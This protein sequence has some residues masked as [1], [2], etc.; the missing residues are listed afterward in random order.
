MSSS[1]G[2]RK[3]VREEGRKE[4]SKDK[5]MGRKDGREE[6]E[7]KEGREEG[8]EGPELPVFDQHFLSLTRLKSESHFL[9]LNRD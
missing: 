3:E 2:G 9:F 6:E 5:K 7:R 1:Q 4:G 8:K